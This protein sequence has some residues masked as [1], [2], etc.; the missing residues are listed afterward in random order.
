MLTIKPSQPT[1]MFA[2][3]RS[4]F[5]VISKLGEGAMNKRKITREF[6]LVFRYNY[7]Y[8]YV[9]MIIG[10]GKGLI[11]ETLRRESGNVCG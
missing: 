4:T 5:R 3:M 8:V 6:P 2:P 7:V 11:Q 1:F 10:G 9:C